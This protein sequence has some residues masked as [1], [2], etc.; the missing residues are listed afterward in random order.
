MNICSSCGK[1]LPEGV[2]FCPDCGQAVTGPASPPEDRAFPEESVPVPEEPIV[3]EAAAPESPAPVEEE[4]AAPEPALPKAPD[5]SDPVSQESGALKRKLRLLL[6]AALA[7]VVVGVILLVTLGKGQSS[8]GTKSDLNRRTSV[9]AFIDEDGVAWIPCSDGSC[10][11]VKEKDEIA[12]ACLTPDEKRVV[13]L[14]EEGEL[15]IANKD[16][17]KKETVAKDAYSAVFVTDDGFFYVTDNDRLY[18]YSFKSGSAAK[19]T[20]D[21]DDVRDVAFAQDGCGLLYLRDGKLYILTAGAEEPV[22]IANT[23]KDTQP[24]YLSDDGK[25]ALWGEKTDSGAYTIYL[26]EKEEKRKLGKVDGRS[27]DSVVSADQKLFLFWGNGDTGSVLLWEK[28]KEEGVKVKLDVG[29]TM[30]A[31]TPSGPLEQSSGVKELYLSASGDE[32]Y[33]VY[34]VD[35]A[36]EKE[37]LFSKAYDW[38]VLD[39]RF[40]WVKQDG[41]LLSGKLK[42]DEIT[43]ETELDEDVTRLWMPYGGK[44]LFYLKGEDRDCEL[45]CYKS[46]EKAPVKVDSD[47]YGYF[48]LLSPSGDSAVYIKDA[49]YN[50]YSGDLMTRSWGGQRTKVSADVFWPGTIG[51]GMANDDLAQPNAIW[52]IAD[53]EDDCGTLYFWN[54]K[55]KKKLASDVDAWGS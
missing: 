7:V 28:G 46:G 41:T 45:Y 50:S 6:V 14:T 51:S 19:M 2:D 39:G 36:G 30:K 49:D 13:V 55:E 48:I 47:V 40:Y 38:T 16:L 20:N 29:W 54:G 18:R 24:L 8:G 42:G 34:R 9:A 17:S 52:F 31:Y 53:V 5:E 1:P 22:K 35:L 32:G 12:S 25:T 11:K 3:S 15:Y 21:V 26:W 4:T 43:E 33:T 23:D 44:H 27:M 10:I 37:K